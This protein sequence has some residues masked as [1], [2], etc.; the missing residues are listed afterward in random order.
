MKFDFFKKER[1][2]GRLAYYCSPSNVVGTSAFPHQV[3]VFMGRRRGRI[4]LAFDEGFGGSEDRDGDGEGL[5]GS[6][7]IVNDGIPQSS[8]K[9]SPRHH[10]VC[11]AH[12]FF[13][14]PF[15]P[16]RPSPSSKFVVQVDWSQTIWLQ[17]GVAADLFILAVGLSHLLSNCF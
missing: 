15:A 1:S 2:R 4:G 7:Q 12:Y 10:G 3:Q 16:G 14:A 17:K 5:L 6:W 8:P 9:S 13:P 11:R